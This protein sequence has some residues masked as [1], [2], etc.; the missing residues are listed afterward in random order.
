MVFQAHKPHNKEQAL[1]SDKSSNKQE[2]EIYKKP[3]T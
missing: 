2:F 1:S 3:D